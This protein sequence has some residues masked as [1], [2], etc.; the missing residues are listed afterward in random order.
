MKKALWVLIANSSVARV[1]KKEGTNLTQIKILDHPESR[2]HNRDLVSDKPGRDFESVGTARHAL[3][4]Q[5][6]PHEIEA[7]SFA[8]E[9]ACFL[10]TAKNNG[11]FDALYLAANP[12]MLGLLRQEFDADTAKLIESEVDKDF[13]QMKPEEIFN[14]FTFTYL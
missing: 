9:V 1:Y 2:L 6:S 8:K 7:M 14:Q 4:P 5:H 10:Q 12:S 13:T 3:E 11:E